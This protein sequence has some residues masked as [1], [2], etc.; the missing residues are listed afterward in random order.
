MVATVHDPDRGA[1]TQIGVPLHLLGT[2]GA[3]QGPQPRPGEHNDA[4]LSE[5][6]YDRAEVTRLATAGAVPAVEVI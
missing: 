3:I 6:G 2:P 4:I 5:L 1:T